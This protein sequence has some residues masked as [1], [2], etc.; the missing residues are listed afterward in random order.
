MTS[1]R[2][3]HDQVQQVAVDDRE[4]GARF[5]ADVELIGMVAKPPP[6]ASSRGSAWSAAA[7]AVVISSM[8]LTSV[9]LRP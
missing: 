7:L 6:G 2:G 1:V 9:T 8:A 3:I 4:P 5:D